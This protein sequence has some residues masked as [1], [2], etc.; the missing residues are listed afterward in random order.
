[1]SEPDAKALVTSIFDGA[2]VKP[3]SVVALMHALAVAQIDGVGGALVIRLPR[4]PSAPVEV[5][6]TTGTVSVR[7]E[8]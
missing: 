7:I 4:K 1:L 2:V 8:P 6:F 3:E 5:S